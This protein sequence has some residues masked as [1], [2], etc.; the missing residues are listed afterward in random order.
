MLISSISLILL[1]I[2][3][4]YL[5]AFLWFH[6]HSC[7]LRLAHTGIYV[8]AG[9]G[10]IGMLVIVAKSAGIDMRYSLLPGLLLSIYAVIKYGKACMP[11]IQRSRQDLYS[12]AVFALCLI[13][14]FHILVPGLLMGRGAYPAIFLAVDSPYYLGQIHELIRNASWPPLS[15]SFLGQSRGY[16]YGAQSVCALFSALTGFPP[17]AS[18]FLIYMP[19]VTSGILCAVWL[20]IQEITRKSQ[21]VCIGI[22]LLLFS[23]YYPVWDI[24]NIFY[25]AVFHI[26]A[27]GNFKHLPLDPES[28]SS[29]YPM[30][31][32]QFGIFVTF[33]LLYCLR[34][35]SL[36]S[37]QRLAMFVVGI[38]IVFKSPYV[39]PLGTGFGL[40]VLYEVYQSRQYSLCMAPAGALLINIAL[41]YISKPTELFSLVFAPWQFFLDTEQLVDTCGTLLIY[42]FPLYAIYTSVIRS[43]LHYRAWQYWG[44]FILPPLVLTNIFCVAKEGVLSPRNF[45]QLLNLLPIFWAM[46]VFTI[47][48]ANWDSILP[49][50]RIMVMFA[51]LVIII[52][53]VGHRAVHAV[54]P[55]IAPQYAHEYVNNRNLAEV[56]MRIPV[57]N[58]V[59]VTNDF[60]YP[61]QNYR[62][63]LA[64]LQFPALF[65]HQTYA[66][67]FRYERYKDSDPRLALQQRFRKS[68]WEPGLEVFARQSGWTHLV[69]HRPSPHPQQIPL[70]LLFEN[71]EYQVYTFKSISMG[72]VY[73][74]F[75]HAKGDGQTL[76][77]T[78]IE[79]QK[80]ASIQPLR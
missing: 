3:C 67:N 75:P 53:P 8:A 9:L 54:V 78:S 62:R 4:C 64:Q 55:L 15:L 59:I 44:F 28:L 73:D 16:H 68:E 47:L 80:M 69:I 76:P 35:F 12:L 36:P 51:T 13:Y 57:K 2:F 43:R 58:S 61:A 19:L 63:D 72:D 40:W 23:I 32:S 7:P 30:L 1:I 46:F 42:G 10:S 45:F 77:H 49:R 5:P 20:I 41:Q 33:V 25:R 29:G 48:Q 70:P 52:A 34:N 17:H 79:F 6:D 39:I 60:R 21:L 71:E 50:Q 37:R 11:V 22:S 26:R 14:F 27:L 56:L 18:A 38:L 74:S 24:A 65:G 31:G 66:I